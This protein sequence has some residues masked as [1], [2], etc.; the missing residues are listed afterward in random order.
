MPKL[1]TVE[2][3]VVMVTPDHTA[4]LR[5]VGQ[6]R[7]LT[8]LHIVGHTADDDWLDTLTTLTVGMRQLVM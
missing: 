6:M 1:A 4:T 2:R 8:S 5:A 3:L 7:A